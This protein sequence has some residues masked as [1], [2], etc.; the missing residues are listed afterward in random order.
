[1]GGGL[2]P[3]ASCAGAGL[4]VARAG[5]QSSGGAGVGDTVLCPSLLP[6]A[7]VPALP[8]PTGQRPGATDDT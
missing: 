5:A 3:V 1:M 8:A 4:G 6:A 2:A 7:L